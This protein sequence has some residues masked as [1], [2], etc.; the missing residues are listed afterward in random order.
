MYTYVLFHIIQAAVVQ[1]EFTKIYKHQINPWP[2]PL[3]YVTRAHT[4]TYQNSL[5]GCL[6]LN[7]V[8][9]TPEWPGNL[10]QVGETYPSRG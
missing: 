2:T 3:L 8:L 9:T 10:N 7:G 1:S 4:H 6:L 5:F